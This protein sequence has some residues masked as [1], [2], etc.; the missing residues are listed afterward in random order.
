[1]L[2]KAPDRPLPPELL[3]SLRE[4]AFLRWIQER[5]DGAA[6]ERFID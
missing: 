4:Q 5:W 3:N 1:V 2:E 6:I